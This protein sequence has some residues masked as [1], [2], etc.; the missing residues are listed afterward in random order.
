MRFEPEV[1]GLD[2]RK[3]RGVIALDEDPRLAAYTVIRNQAA[4]GWRRTRWMATPEPS[5]GRRQQEEARGSRGALRQHLEQFGIEYPTVREGDPENRVRT[6]YAGGKEGRS[7][8]HAPRRL[9]TVS[10]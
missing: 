6:A 8:W 10:E 9:Q 2:G 1:F 7:R 5:W 3:M 4:S